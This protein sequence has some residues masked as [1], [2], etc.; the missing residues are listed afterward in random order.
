MIM[1]VND[2]IKCSLEKRKPY[3][4]PQNT[5]PNQNKN[6]IFN[7]VKLYIYFLYYLSNIK[8]VKLH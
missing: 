6:N 1:S 7:Y 3:K 2:L 5:K 4:K 8:S